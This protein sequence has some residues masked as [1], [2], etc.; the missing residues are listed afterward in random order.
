MP[1]FVVPRIFPAVVSTT[2]CESAG[3]PPAARATFKAEPA[4]SLCMNA[5]PPPRSDVFIKERRS[6]SIPKRWLFVIRLPFT[7]GPILTEFQQEVS[8]MQAGMRAYCF[9]LDRAD[10][11]QE[12]RWHPR[13]TWNVRYGCARLRFE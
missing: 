1:L 3:G 11:G 8:I 9:Q 4:K 6:T 13:E 12:S 2:G 7:L 10:V 5:A